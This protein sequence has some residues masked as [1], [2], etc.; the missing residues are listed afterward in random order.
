MQNAMKNVLNYLVNDVFISVCKDMVSAFS[1]RDLMLVFACNT[2]TSIRIMTSMCPECSATEDGVRLIAAMMQK[3][4]ADAVVT[5]MSGYEDDGHDCCLSITIETLLE[6]K[7]M[8]WPYDID[9]C[10]IVWHDRV[11]RPNP[12][13]CFALLL[14]APAGMAQA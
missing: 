8:A 14:P 9:N 4:Q 2:E 10:S 6:V 5:V 11:D 3:C 7:R 1:S 12:E 13:P